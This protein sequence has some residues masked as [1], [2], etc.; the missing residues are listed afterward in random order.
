MPAGTMAGN[1]E[2]VEGDSGHTNTSSENI[3]VR[4]GYSGGSLAGV[5]PLQMLW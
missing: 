3:P 2:G 4:A 1:P 5:N